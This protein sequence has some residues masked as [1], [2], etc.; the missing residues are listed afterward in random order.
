[1]HA[2]QTKTSNRTEPNC[3]KTERAENQIESKSEID[4]ELKCTFFKINE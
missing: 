1:M 4:N 3:T 2:Q